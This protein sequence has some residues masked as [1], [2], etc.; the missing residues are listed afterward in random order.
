MNLFSENLQD[1]CTVAI[2]AAKKAGELISSYINKEISVQNKTGGLSLASQVITEVDLKSQ[3]II[4]K[5]LEPTFQKYDLALLTE[6]SSDDKSR[7][8]KDYFWCIDPLDGTLPFIEK[9]EGY[10]V[11]IALV[12]KDGTPQIGV[13]YN[14]VNNTLYHAI[15]GNRAFKNKKEWE[16]SQQENTF[17]F[18]CDR[19][20]KKHTDFEHIISDLKT[21]A[22]ENGPNNFKLI[23]QGGAAM[24][25]IWVLENAPACYFKFPKKENSGGSIWDFAASAC[26]FNE[27]GAISTNIQGNKLDLNRKDSTFMNHEGIIYS[28]DKEFVEWIMKLK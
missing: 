17:T 13:V 3:E 1:L 16:L 15:K 26:I 12:S 22:K 24:N 14:P 19:S 20:F 5:E 4:L 6:E 27:I 23:S 25:A 28:S 21:F 7:F 10:S 11:S 2:S 8:E 18:I 9:K